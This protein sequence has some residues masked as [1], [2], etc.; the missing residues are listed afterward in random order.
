M[1]AHGV[2][3]RKRLRECTGFEIEV[4]GRTRG[5]GQLRVEP[6]PGVVVLGQE[7]SARIVQA[8]IGVG[9]RA[10]AARG[11]LQIQDV[12]HAGRELDAEPVAIACVFQAPGARSI[13]GDWPNGAVV[14]AKVS[15]KSSAGIDEL[16]TF[17]R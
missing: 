11:A 13:D 2:A 6:E 9:E 1:D 3:A 14:S 7:G 5:K 12:P 17:I 15:R 4:A 8:Q 10:E 16:E